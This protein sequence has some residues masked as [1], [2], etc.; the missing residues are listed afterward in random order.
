MASNR[1]NTQQHLSKSILLEET[2]SPIII[3]MIIIF[4]C[5]MIGLFLYWSTVSKLDEVAIAHGEIVPTSQVRKIQHATGGV[6]EKITIQEGQFVTKGQTVV[7][8]HST[9]H[10]AK[11]DVQL[12]Q[13][14]AS[15]ARK[16]RLM[17]FIDLINNALKNLSPEETTLHQH[18]EKVMEQLSNS[19][20]IEGALFE[21][22]IQQLKSNLNTL[23]STKSTL[24][25]Q[26][27]S[28]EKEYALREMMVMQ[29][30]ES[31]VTLIPLKRQLKRV[32]S[33]L[34]QIP[35]Q[36]KKL[37]INLQKQTL[38][39]LSEVD[40]TLLQTQK[41]IQNY[42]SR[43][44]SSSIKIPVNGLIHNLVVQAPGDVVAPGSTLFR[45]VP[46]DAKMIAEVRIAPKDIGH[47][48][49][50]QPAI[51]KFTAYDFSRYGGLSGKVTHISP[52]TFLDPQGRPYYK[53]VI[54]L[55]KSYFGD[56]PS[57]NLILSGMTVEADVKTGNKT[58]LQYL[59]K[60]IFASSQQALRER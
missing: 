36:R 21:S 28:L 34:E 4:G 18:E 2:G 48:H 17:S 54:S 6:V 56:D 50:N 30:Q 43:L 9:E 44:Y 32:S 24:Q 29:E 40:K 8:L 11:L 60:P 52:T 57:Q 12:V 15:I 49:I 23:E 53:G 26:K 16:Q 58:I 27:V 38:L 10:Q 7:W 20:T 25:N 51:M 41:L 31:R 13:Q 46:N 47:V 35:F 1:T 19:T 5:S 59:L 37:F 14:Q 3:R 42:R 45:I 33:D 55:E 22:Q 39:E